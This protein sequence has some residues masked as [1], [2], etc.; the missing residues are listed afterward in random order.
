MS[1]SKFQDSEVTTKGVINGPRPSPLRINKDSHA[2]HKPSSSS[3]HQ[4]VNENTAHLASGPK[5]Q[6]Q[7]QSLSAKRQPV[8]IY[9]HSPKVIHAQARDF[10]ALVQKLTGL[11]RSSEDEKTTTTTMKSESSESTKDDGGSLSEEKDCGV[12]KNVV[13]EDNESSSVLTTDDKFVGEVKDSSAVS[14]MYKVSNPYFV[15]APLFT[16][17]S[18]DQFFC[19]S[20]PNSIFQS[21]SMANP[22][23]PSFM[24]FMKGFPEY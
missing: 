22:I 17:N 23:S 10:M 5:Q 8:I 6:Q 15:D 21:P 3:S 4:P 9:T 18:N 14:P 20:R 19:S 7:Q 11:S 12:N 13:Y 2:I 16:P 24:D 1:P